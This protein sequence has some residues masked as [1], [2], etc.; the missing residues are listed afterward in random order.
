[1]DSNCEVQVTTLLRQ[2]QPGA[3]EQK[4]LDGANELVR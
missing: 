3:G 2:K 1:M 4:D